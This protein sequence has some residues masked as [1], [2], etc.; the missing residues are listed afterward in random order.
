MGSLPP[1]WFGLGAKLL[2]PVVT[3]GTQT[4]ME[5][6]SPSALTTPLAVDVPPISPGELERLSVQYAT[7]RDP[8]LRDTLV[9]Y[10]QKLVRSIASRFQNAGEALED[11]VQVGNIGLINALER[12][13]PSQGTRF[14]TYA[15]PTILGEIK[16]HF[17]D[18]VNGLKVPR[19]VQELNQSARRAQQVLA[20]ELGRQPTHGEI[21]KHLGVREDHVAVAL[22][23]HD[24]TSIMSLDTHLEARGNSD[25]ASLFDVVGRLDALLQEFDEYNDLRTALDTLHPSERE[26]IALRFFDELSQAKIAKQLNVSQMYVSRLQQRA[27]KRLHDYLLDIPP[28]GEAT[29]KT[30]KRKRT[31][32]QTNQP[33]IQPG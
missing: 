5:L 27:L 28:E 3:M 13:D 26:V 31:R 6:E 11:L 10:H 23:A 7:T 18:K 8:K 17:R 22:E 30:R 14:S 19:W 29:S 33:Q 20:V 1:F 21:A 25:S 15:T 4:K 2:L 32:T 16:R 12:Y 24:M 9:V